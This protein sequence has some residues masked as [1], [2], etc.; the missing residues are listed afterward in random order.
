MVPTIIITII[1]V[2]DFW[3]AFYFLVVVGRSS[4]LLWVVYYKRKKIYLDEKM[5]AAAAIINYCYRFIWD[6][7]LLP[8]FENL[9]DRLG[10]GSWSGLFTIVP[11][12]IYLFGLEGQ[13]QRTRYIL[14]GRNVNYK[15]KHWDLSNNISLF[16]LFS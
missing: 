5:A 15:L 12:L 10:S 8:E 3:D 16:F 9:E 1:I 6:V 14:H 4:F 13:E 11:R 7:L 2:V